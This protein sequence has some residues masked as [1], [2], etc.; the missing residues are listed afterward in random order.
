MQQ[1]EEQQPSP[2]PTEPS[3]NAANGQETP[4]TPEE[5]EAY[6][7]AVAA[8]TEMIHGDDTVHEGIMSMLGAEKPADALISATMLVLTEIDKKLDLPEVVIFE[9]AST[10]FD[11]LVELGETAGLFSLDES[12]EKKIAGALA[13]MIL[14]TYGGEAEDIQQFL[15]GVSDQ[16]AASTLETYKEIAQ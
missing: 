1:T 15:S 3:N 13:Q 12:Q 8:A 9:L 16:E 6:E 7:N 10:I 4:A 2:Q 14:Q 11:L 5:Q